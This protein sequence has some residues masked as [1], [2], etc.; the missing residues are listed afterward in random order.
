MNQF[1]KAY[2]DA[3]EYERFFKSRPDKVR[4]ASGPSTAAAMVME[5]DTIAKFFSNIFP[6]RGALGNRA[7]RHAISSRI[8]Q[9]AGGP[10]A[11]RTGCTRNRFPGSWAG[12]CASW[13]SF[14]A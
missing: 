11:T 14:S 7:V 13:V 6:G 8:R 5:F 2:I 10:V 4:K 9:V 1:E 12:R 3:T